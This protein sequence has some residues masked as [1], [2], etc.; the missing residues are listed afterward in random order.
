[1]SFVETSR[2][3]GHAVTK[4]FTSNNSNMIF[5][6]MKVEDTSSLLNF[7]YLYFHP[8]RY[9]YSHMK[10]GDSGVKYQFLQDKLLLTIET[11]KVNKPFSKISS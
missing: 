7:R 11:V 3:A 1:M 9:P 10:L 6:R 5:A 8:D 4:I 2:T